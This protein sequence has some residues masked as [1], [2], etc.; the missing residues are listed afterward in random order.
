M[1]IIAI[2]PARGGSKGIPKKNLQKVCGVSLLEHALHCVWKSKYS[3]DVIVSTDCMEIL[4][5]ANSVG[6]IGEYLRPTELAKDDS[7][8]IDSVLDVLSWSKKN[9]GREYDC[10]V[11]LQPTSP[12]RLSSDLDAALDSFL[13]SSNDT[14]LVSVVAMSEHPVECIAVSD[15]GW[16]YLVKPQ[17]SY[18]GRQCYNQN[19]FFINGAIYICKA[20][21]LIH[22]QSFID[23]GKTI[24]YEMPKSRSVD[25]DTEDDLILANYFA[26]K[27]FSNH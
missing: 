22:S 20:E 19:Y 11:L 9:H 27:M 24:L 8:T 4:E 14:S 13:A 10:V 3:L 7:R 26:K 16:D 25:I 17:V 2:I 23:Q 18:R 6:Y 21:F 15:D 12:L 5:H 1:K